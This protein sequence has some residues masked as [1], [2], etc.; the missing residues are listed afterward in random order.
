MTHKPGLLI[1]TASLWTACV[2]PAA[3]IEPGEPPYAAAVVARFPA[4]ALRYDTP[5]LRPGRRELTTN[6]EIAAAL[7]AAVAR[8]GA[9]AKL[10][11]AGRSQAGVPIEAVVFARGGDTASRPTVLMIGQQHGDEPAG[12]E[13]VLVI[14]QE[15][16]A[17]ALAPLLERINVIVLPRA[18]PDGA[19]ADRRASAGGIDVNRDHLLLRTPEAL[20]LAQ[21]AREHRP[22]V[23]VDSHEYVVDASY[24]QKFG[25]LQRFDL[26]FQYAMTANLPPAL[27]RASEQWFRQPLLAAT[28][29]EG[30]TLEWYHAS[31]TAPDDKRLSMGGTQVDTGR[32]VN[33]LRSAVSLLLES[34]GVG[35]GRWHFARRVHSHVVALR[36][37]LDSAARHAQALAALQGELD[38]QIA[39]LACHGETVISAGQTPGRRELL[40]IDPANG[41]DKTIVVDWNSSL[42]LRALRTRARPCGYWLAPDA[43]DAVRR[44]RALGLAVHRLDSATELQAEAWRETARA[45]SAATVTVAVSLEP[46][47]I[48]APAGS[49]YLPLDQPL[50]NLAIAALEPDTPHSY[51]AHKLLPALDR[52][53]RVMARP[54]AKFVD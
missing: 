15:L 49:F 34:R 26:L 43:A 22:A 36:S 37:I 7:R 24:L 16:A 8:G 51:F 52:A 10:L 38:A 31:S 28:A 27:A 53:A 48:G 12:S 13:A 20:A 44:L 11:A 29:G 32:N 40:F 17:G 9:N 18:N 41:A 4:P 5:A 50:A 47:R 46:K 1:A 19:A 54:E 33:G 45:E 3:E 2:A 21:L 42:E 30:L 23:V 6:A 25:A 39:A 14:A 35:L